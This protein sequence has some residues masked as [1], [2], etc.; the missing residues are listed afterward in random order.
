MARCSILDALLCHFIVSEPSELILI[1]IAA[2]TWCPR[3]FPLR[4]A[5]NAVRIESAFI[6]TLVLS[7]S[8]LRRIID[9]AS[10]MLTPLGMTTSLDVD[11]SCTAANVALA[12]FKFVCALRSRMVTFSRVVRS[13]LATCA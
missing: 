2:I 10:K 6:F 5:R 7:M 4:L 9:M 8:A 11:S 1:L 12:A 3:I 13:L